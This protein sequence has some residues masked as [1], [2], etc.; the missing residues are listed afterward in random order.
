M[1]QLITLSAAKYRIPLAIV[2]IC[3][4]L[5]LSGA[6]GNEQSLGGPDTTTAAPTTG[7]PLAATVTPVP[8]SSPT[9]VP[10]IRPNTARSNAPTATPVSV[11]A[12]TLP[13]GDQYIFADIL[14]LPASAWELNG[15]GALKLP[16]TDLELTSEPLSADVVIAKWTE[17][18]SG[19]RIIVNGD[20]THLTGAVRELGD[21]D[22]LLCEAGYGV[23]MVVPPSR[24]VSTVG[25]IF[26]WKVE[27]SVASPWWGPTLVL[28]V[29]D[30][31][32]QPSYP[33][34]TDRR[35]Q[36]YRRSVF[37]VGEEVWIDQFTHTELELSILTISD[38]DQFCS[39]EVPTGDR[40]F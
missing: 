9:S 39:N 8:R 10:T 35:Q 38:P 4:L 28:D 30:Q 13:A 21:F 34:G 3:W 18:L 37:I 16:P 27:H 15:Y 6:C 20:P 7:T 36:V 1:T 25:S 12:P 5:V 11:I 29:R 40:V 32:F 33:T 14:G 22:L 17:F 23:V 24:E 31:T 26:L 19:T 2:A